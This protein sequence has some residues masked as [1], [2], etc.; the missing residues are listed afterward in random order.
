[1]SGDK[2]G[3]IVLFNRLTGSNSVQI[4]C[5]LPFQLLGIYNI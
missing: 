1:M 4:G 2:N 3:A 5:G